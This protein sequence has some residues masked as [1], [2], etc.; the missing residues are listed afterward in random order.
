MNDTEILISLCKELA[1]DLA[2][3]HEFLENESISVMDLPEE[4]THTKNLIK[5]AYS[6]LKTL[7]S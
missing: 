4:I 3:W 5:R 2:I 7:K 1:D 6:T